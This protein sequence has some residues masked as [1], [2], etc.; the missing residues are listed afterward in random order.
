MLRPEYKRDMHKN[1]IVLKETVTDNKTDYGMKMVAN[2]QIQGF[3]EVEICSIDQTKEYHYNVTEKQP[4]TV[5]YR[6]ENLKEDQIRTILTEII[7]TL[8]RGREYLLLEDSFV[9]APEYIYMSLDGT[10]TELI[11]YS[12]F[13]ENIG[14]QLIRLIEYMMDRVDY[15]DKPAVFLVYGIYKI[16]REEGCTFDKLLEFLCDNGELEEE[17]HRQE[18]KE[19]EM[20]EEEEQFLQIA[21]EIE[22]EEEKKKYPIWV[23]A[24]VGISVMVSLILV[25]IAVKMGFMFDIVTGKILIG[26]MVAFFAVVGALE[27]Y[28]LL[29]ILDEKNQIGYIDKRTDY[30]KPVEEQRIW[31][32]NI[33]FTEIKE[34]LEKEEQATVVLAERKSGYFLEPKNKDAYMSIFI[35]EFPFFIG[36]LKTKVDYAIKSQNVSRF[37]AKM[38]QEG[39][40]FYLVDMNSTNG[41]YVNGERLEAGEK[42]EIVLGDAITFADVEYR[43]C[44]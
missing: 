32:N 15:K 2:N 8:K 42:K 34:P 21:E 29:R 33:K 43:F 39:E 4:M 1:Y 31:E 35:P 13:K 19:K 25:V 22:N 6:K 41:T 16:S 28:C 20:W 10:E 26:R 38:E 11:Y 9:L 7:T 18:V 5:L 3:L 14:E 37:H 36:S 30:I 17:M 24:G 12:A 40:K 27:G 23:W 44:K